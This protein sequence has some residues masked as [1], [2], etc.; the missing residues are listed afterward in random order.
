M[1]CE[2]VHTLEDAPKLRQL[3]NCIPNMTD[4]AMT[5]LDSFNAPG[6]ALLFLLGLA[7]VHMQ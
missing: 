5:L 4:R 7:I 6:L 1:P 3:V 2:F